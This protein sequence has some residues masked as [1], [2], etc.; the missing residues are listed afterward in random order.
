MDFLP[1]SIR[2]KGQ[3]VLIVG[4][5]HVATHKAQILRRFTEDATVIAPEI[6]QDMKELGFTWKEKAF[7]KQDLDGVSL[8]FICTGNH[9][10]NRQILEMAHKHHVLASVCDNPALCDFTSPAI[11]KE[12]G[13]TIAVASDGKDVRRSIRVRNRIK[14]LIDNGILSLD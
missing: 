10:L 4:G 13:L 9:A 8:M 14:E 6:S 1:V 7:E 3:K 2:I 5:G 11:A 12:E